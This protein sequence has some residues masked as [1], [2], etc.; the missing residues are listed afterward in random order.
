MDFSKTRSSKFSGLMLNSFPDDRSP[1]MLKSRSL[2]TKLVGITMTSTA[3]EEISDSYCF[4]RRALVQKSIGSI[5]A[6]VV[7]SLFSALLPELL[8]YERTCLLLDK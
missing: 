7:T 3:T 4:D 6:L 2:G 8:S 1:L 5:G